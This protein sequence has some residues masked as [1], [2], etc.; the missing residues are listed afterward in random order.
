MMCI[1]RNWSWMEWIAHETTA[2][3]TP[4]TTFKM[5]HRTHAF[6]RFCYVQTNPCGC[7]RLWL[8]WCW[9][10]SCL[11]SIWFTVSK[12]RFITLSCIHAN[13]VI[14]FWYANIIWNQDYFY[15]GRVIIII[16]IILYYAVI[17][18]DLTDR[19]VT[20]GLVSSEQLDN[21]QGRIIGVI[22]WNGPV[23]QSI[24]C[25]VRRSCDSATDVAF[26]MRLV[27]G[28]RLALVSSSHGIVMLLEAIGLSEGC[29]WLSL[30][31]SGEDSSVL[32]IDRKSVV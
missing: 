24:S 27:L 13:C 11:N 4:W 1:V 10:I 23:K 22:T 6:F 12:L 32:P 3:M 31:R 18:L 19:L 28:W 8:S 29:L 7:P 15:S 30:D 16:I 5:N 26:L 14:T 2:W 17:G 20:F 21:T 25:L 9:N